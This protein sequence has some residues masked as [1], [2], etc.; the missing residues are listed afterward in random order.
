MWFRQLFWPCVTLF[1]V[2]ELFRRCL[3]K[4]SRN[5]TLLLLTLRNNKFASH[6]MD[7]CEDKCVNVNKN[8]TDATVRRYLLHTAASVGFLFVLSY[9]A[10]NHELKKINMLIQ[11]PVRF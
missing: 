9:D 10:W 5:R 4:G 1:V 8:P 11:F 2:F 3:K 7:E 6:G